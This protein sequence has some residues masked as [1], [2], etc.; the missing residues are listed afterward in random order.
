MRVNHENRSD[1]TSPRK[2]GTSRYVRSEETIR[3]DGLRRRYCYSFIPLLTLS[4]RVGFLTLL[5]SRW[6]PP[7][8]LNEID[9][10]HEVSC[11]SVSSRLHRSHTRFAMSLSTGRNFKSNRAPRED[12][13]RNAL[14]SPRRCAAPVPF[15]LSMFVAQPSFC[16]VRA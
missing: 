12:R 15:C 11:L 2:R 14:S 13:L 3:D 7:M 8:R 5:S 1:A 9:T 16:R 10:V 6:A 4:Y